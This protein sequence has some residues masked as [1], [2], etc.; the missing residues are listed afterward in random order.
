[1][2]LQSDANIFISLTESLFL[3]LIISYILKNFIIIN[4]HDFDKIYFV[5]THIY[6]QTNRVNLFIGMQRT[7][8]EM[9]QNQKFFIAVLIA[10]LVFSGG[11]WTINILV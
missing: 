7:Y 11:M 10:L 6:I 1:M 3:L 9:A 4:Y 8:K 5:H 2:R